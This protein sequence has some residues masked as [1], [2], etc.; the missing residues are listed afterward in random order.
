MTNAQRMAAYN[1]DFVSRWQMVWIMGAL[2]S[3]SGFLAYVAT[4]GI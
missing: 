2:I 1:D 3:V 4:Q